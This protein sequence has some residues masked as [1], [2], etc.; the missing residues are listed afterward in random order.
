VFG[1][2]RRGVVFF[3]A[4][5]MRANTEMSICISIYVIMMVMSFQITRL[6]SLFFQLN[7]NF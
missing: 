5:Q 7:V 1:L 6:F 2:R 3:S 4:S